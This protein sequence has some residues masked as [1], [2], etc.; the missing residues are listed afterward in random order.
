[1]PQECFHDEAKR[2]R[3]LAK[4]PRLSLKITKHAREEMDKDNIKVLSILS[5]LKRCKVVRVE[6]NRFE[7]TW[8]AEGSDI[9]G[10]PMTVVVVAY[11]D[12]IKIKVIT[13]WARSH[14]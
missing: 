13:A 12:R 2:L 14:K 3:D 8:N 10:N 4:N 1:M 6:Q 7:E 5:M 9:D 11:E